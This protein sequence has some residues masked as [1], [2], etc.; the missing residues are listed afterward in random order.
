MIQ[1]EYKKNQISLVKKEWNSFSG[2]VVKLKCDRNFIIDCLNNRVDGRI[3]MFVNP[4]VFFVKKPKNIENTIDFDDD[5]SSWSKSPEFDSDFLEK[6]FS[7]TEHALWAISNNNGI[8][9]LV[10]HGIFDDV[11][12]AD[13]IDQL[14]QLA[15]TNPKFLKYKNLYSFEDL[16]DDI[17]SKLSLTKKNVLKDLD[18][19]AFSIFEDYLKNENEEDRTKIKEN[20][21]EYLSSIYSDEISD[22]YS[23]YGIDEFEIELGT[24]LEDFKNLI[25][26]IKND[27]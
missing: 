15:V 19:F 20:F 25:F 26:D 1:L 16:D 13:Q 23:K 18:N 24:D 14:W 5:L 4:F 17:K 3:L 6:I 8:I 27:N 11:T 7:L 21:K 22:F 10:N 12:D 9:D 2:I